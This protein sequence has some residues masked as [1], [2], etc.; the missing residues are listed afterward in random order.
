MPLAALFAALS[1]LR[2]TAYAIGLLRRVRLPVPVVVV[3]NLNVGGTGKTPAVIWLVRA[4][5]TRGYRP[6]VISRGYRGDG[7]LRAVG[8]DCPP[9]IG[10]DEPVLIARLAHC[11]VWVGRDRGAAARR[12]LDSNPDVNVII[13]DDGL[14][15][16]RL[17]RN[18]ELAVVSARQR[19][20]NRL[21]LPAGPLREPA[22]RLRTVDATI[23]NGGEL[24]GLPVSTFAMQLV[25]DR[26]CNLVEPKKT[27]SPHDF[28]GKRV[29]AVAGIG[30]PERFFAHLR[31]LGLSFVPHA[32]AD[33][34]AFRAADLDFEDAD[35]VIMT[36]KDAIKCARFAPENWWAL[37]VEARIDDTLVDL[38]IQKM[39]SDSGY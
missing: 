11:P 8:P 19:F 33:H 10:G 7:Q 35:A 2:K 13:S 38:V 39:G 28:D 23:V 30:D 6:G 37:P 29:H 25:G 18:C 12:L 31:G 22:S 15:H 21:L 1:W 32:F 20:G 34:H 24:P 9:E 16:Y 4:L 5:R 3:G 14:Q 26:F 27:A 17:T 36:Q